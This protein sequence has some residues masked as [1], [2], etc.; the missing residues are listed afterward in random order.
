LPA[1]AAVRAGV[2]DVDD[3]LAEICGPRQIA[4]LRAGLTALHQIREVLQAPG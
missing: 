2:A 3:R 1:A 4:G